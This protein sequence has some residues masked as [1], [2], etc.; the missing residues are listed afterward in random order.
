MAISFVTPIDQ[1]N[2]TRRNV[3]TISFNIFLG[4][5]YRFC[6][7]RMPSDRLQISLL[8]LSEFKQINSLPFPLKLSE[9]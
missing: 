1:V 4:R 6:L 2:N 8:I 5:S 3:E 7:Y 9:N